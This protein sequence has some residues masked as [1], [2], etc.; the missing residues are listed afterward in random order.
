[1]KSFANFTVKL[2]LKVCFES[3][4]FAPLWLFRRHI[5]LINEKYVKFL[6]LLR[7]VTLNHE[8]NQW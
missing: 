7:Q 3:K 2:T 4:F 1:M 6:R 5:Y 8:P